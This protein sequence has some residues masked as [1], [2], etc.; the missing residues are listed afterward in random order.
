MPQTKDAKGE[1]RDVFHPVTSEGRKALNEAILTEFGA[2]LDSM[3]EQKESALNKIKES[4]KATKDK[5]PQA[6]DKT[7]NEKGQKKA[8]QP[9]H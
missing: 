4:A 8:E 7:K 1:W 2:A 3:V 9:T 6:G 5:T